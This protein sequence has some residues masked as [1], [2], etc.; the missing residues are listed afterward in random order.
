MTCWLLL[1]IISTARLGDRIRDEVRSYVRVKQDPAILG[2]SVSPQLTIDTEGLEKSCSLLRVCFKLCVKRYCPTVS[3]GMVK[4]AFKVDGDTHKIS[5]RNGKSK[6]HTK[7]SSYSVLIPS[8]THNIQAAFDQIVVEEPVEVSSNRPA[9]S[10]EDSDP[11]ED[12]ERAIILSLVAGILSVWD[13]TPD[14]ATYGK[15]PKPK[16]SSLFLNPT[17]D[18]RMTIAQRQLNDN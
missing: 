3:I 7:P 14:S 1:H 5:L 4:D 6:S 12:S 17:S 16:A 11:C 13:I 10:H 18:A 8:R 2:F 15:I 9:S